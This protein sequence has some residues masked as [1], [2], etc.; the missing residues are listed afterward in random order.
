M[1]E[2]FKI[3][4]IIKSIKPNPKSQAKTTF[5]KLQVKHTALEKT[6]SWLKAPISGQ[7]LDTA[8]FCNCC[9]HLLGESG[10]FEDCGCTS[11]IATSSCSL[12][13]SNNPSPLFSL[14]WV[15][16][17]VA[18]LLVSPKSGASSIWS[19]LLWTA[20]CIDYRNAKI[21]N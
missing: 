5:K 18:V 21:Q 11:G 14:C 3:K 6:F 8:V 4:V 2:N 9:F 15:H 12:L 17:S 13:P 1:S 20:Q 7:S 16:I 10:F 19:F